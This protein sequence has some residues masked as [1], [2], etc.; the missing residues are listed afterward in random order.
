MEINKNVGNLTPRCPQTSK[1]MVTKFGMDDEIG[2]STPMQ[3][4]ITIR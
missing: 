2:D 1:P 3:N 4:F